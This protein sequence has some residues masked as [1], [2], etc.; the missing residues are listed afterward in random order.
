MPLPFAMHG[1]PVGLRGF[2]QWRGYRPS[3]EESQ[4]YITIVRRGTLPVVITGTFESYALVNLEWY[5]HPRYAYPGVRL[6]HPFG[7]G[8]PIG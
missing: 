7:L 8:L 6:R 1:R 3:R 4:W 5:M 2:R